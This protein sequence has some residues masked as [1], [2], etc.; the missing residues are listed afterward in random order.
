MRLVPAL[1]LVL[2]VAITW[3]GESSIAPI[4]SVILGAPGSEI[5]HQVAVNG[6]VHT[7]VLATTL[8]T[9]ERSDP[10][11]I[12]AGEGSSLSL[13]LAISAGSAPLLL[14]IQEL[15]DR[16]P[17]VFGYTVEV[18]GTEVYFR[19]YEEVGAGPNH[20]FV[21]VPRRLAPDGVLHV[22]LRNQGDAPVAIGRMW[23]YGDFSQL[24]KADGTWRPMGMLAEAQTL[25]G[26]VGKP[27]KQATYE[28]NRDMP[29]ERDPAAWKELRNSFTDGSA[30][31]PGFQTT[32]HYLG[33]NGADLQVEI[34]AAIR[35][36]GTSGIQ[37]QYKFMGGDW[38]GHPSLLDGMGGDFYDIRYSQ[39][40]YDPALKRYGPT[41]P[42]TPGGTIWPTAGAT[43]LNRFVVD[44]SRLTARLLGERL[45]LWAAQ[46]LR[47]AETCLVGD[48]GPSY[49]WEGGFGDFTP[50]LVAAA[51]R[52]GV[53]IDPGQLTPAARKW[54]FDNLTKRFAERCRAIA[55]GL[56]RD[57]IPVDQGVVSLPTSQLADAV[58]SHPFMNQV[59]PL[60]DRQWEGWQNGANEHAWIGGEPLEYVNPSF[61]DYI[62]AQ[63]RLAMVNL[64]RPIL[65]LSYLETL[66]QW[67]MGHIACYQEFSGDAQPFSQALAGV[68]ERPSLPARH[69]ERSLVALDFSRLEALVPSALVAQ[70]SNLRL[71]PT[72]VKT[73]QLID[74]TM[75]G[76]L[77][78]HLD[79]MGKVL[80]D[81]M[82]LHL[83]F[84]REAGRGKNSLA[85]KVSVAA[86]ADADR[87]QPVAEITSDRFSRTTYWP[88]LCTA[89][90]PLGTALQGATQGYVEITV[91]TTA[92]AVETG[93]C[94]VA[95]RSG[96]D[97]RSGQLMG[98]LPSNREVRTRRL[99]L[100]DR[101][102]TERLLARHRAAG[103]A[104]ATL[105]EAERLIASGQ[106]R[107]ARQHLSGAH[108][109]LLPAR[110]AVRGM[111][112]LGPYP[113]SI[114]WSER[115]ATALVELRQTDRNRVE[116][117]IDGDRDQSAEIRCS[118]MAPGGSYAMIVAPDNVI[119][120]IADPVGTLVAD[121][122][123]LVTAAC[124]VSARPA[125]GGAGFL[126][127]R[128]G[129][130]PSR[131]LIAMCSDK[132]RYEVQDPTLALFNP[133]HITNAAMVVI[134]RHRDGEAGPVM[135][136]VPS[137]G[138]RVEVTLDDAG[139]AIG[140]RSTHGEASGR[141]R[142][143]TPPAV[144]PAPCN[145][146]IELEDGR[147]FEFMY[148]HGAFTRFS[149]PGLK[150]DARNNSLDDYSAA[151]KP[152]MMVELK[153][154]PPLIA[155]FL[156]RLLSV[157]AKP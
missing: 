145:G 109:L 60:F 111:G 69:Y 45:G 144:H 124:R 1:M 76:R 47:P 14:E 23:A 129:R 34:D 30:L 110:F 70:H 71:S 42:R 85:N 115:T 152:G 19:T 90:I 107:I 80:P 106:L 53:M 142:V 116:L 134:E 49:W 33:S 136:A 59:F 141:I 16:R 123:G 66:Y 54:M 7:A 156:P 133:L 64:F 50:D 24:T 35:K 120:I 78:L 86:G 72:M 61:S 63:G 18:N 10:A 67:G 79:G 125:I 112:P 96:W 20:V 68:D 31:A 25:V 65:D 105:A 74:P 87:L 135:Q 84:G 138:D 143:F 128:T 149:V 17:Q 38:G 94:K 81:T 77:M 122:A 119:T 137:R 155:G 88:R 37:W 97:R 82:T 9:L 55:E 8:G 27:G 28:E 6:R 26:W 4:D 92:R 153:Y 154:S 117:R 99:W 100:Q 13:K 62:A 46:G 89:S 98:D 151:I 12:I 147:R 11:R 36:A 132:Q 51:A 22:T 41:W 15:H 101:A 2:T 91:T 58:Y 103:G 75:P 39:A 43:T 40:V 3:A 114:T 131:T 127:K 121:P 57:V 140:L 139:Q 56:G 21:D 126:A 146:V 52:D 73:I 157:T 104:A 108:S 83:D 93:L 148:R 29:V 5:M 130:V 32:S 48:E 102:V 150:P 118:G 95:V 113:V 44:R